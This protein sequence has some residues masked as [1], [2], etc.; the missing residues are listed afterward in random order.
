MIIR[1]EIT[2]NGSVA[3]IKTK[4]GQKFT[5]RFDKDSDEIRIYSGKDKSGSFTFQFDSQFGIYHLKQMDVGKFKRMGLGRDA[6]TFF[7]KIKVEDLY[8]ALE[9]YLNLRDNVNY[10]ALLFVTAMIREEVIEGIDNPEE[11]AHF[12]PE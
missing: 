10:D 6:I 7:R 4:K 11:H 9:D 1:E 2:Y 5:L 12:F 3:F 8:I